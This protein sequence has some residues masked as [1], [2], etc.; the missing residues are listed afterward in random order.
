MDCSTV[1]SVGDL[2]FLLLRADHVDWKELLSRSFGVEQADKEMRDAL[3]D[4]D[5]EFAKEFMVSGAMGL[6]TPATRQAVFCQLSKLISRIRVHS[7]QLLKLLQNN[8]EAITQLK[9]YK[10]FLHWLS[11]L[12]FELISDPDWHKKLMESLAIDENKKIEG[13]NGAEV[14]SKHYLTNGNKDEN[15]EEYEVDDE[16]GI[17]ENDEENSI[18]FATRISALT[19][20]SLIFKPSIDSIG[21]DSFST[22]LDL[23]HW[24]G[25]VEQ[26][27]LLFALDDQ[28]EAC[29]K[30]ALNLLNHFVSI[31]WFQTHSQ[32]SDEEW[33]FLRVR[34]NMPRHQQAIKFRL[35]FHLPRMELKLQLEFIETL[36]KMSEESSNIVTNASEGKEHYFVEAL[37]DSPQLHSL[38]NALH[39]SLPYVNF[40]MLDKGSLF[41]SRILSL[42][43]LVDKI[44]SPV[45]HSLS[46]EG[47]MPSLDDASICVKGLF[48]YNLIEILIIIATDY[49]ICA[50]QLTRTCFRAHK[51]ISGI[52]AH[53]FSQY[54]TSSFSSSLLKNDVNQYL[55]QIASYFWQQLTECRHRGAFEAASN[56]FST[57]VCPRL[58]TICAENCQLNNYKTLFPYSPKQWL[59]QILAAL[60]GKDDSH[61]LCVTRRSAGLPHLIA[62]LLEN[63]P[64]KMLNDEQGLFHQTI[65]Q[66][67]DCSERQNPELEVHCINVLRLLFMHSKFSELVLPHVECAFRVTI[68]GSSSEFWPVRNAHTQ[69]F[70]ALIKRVFGTPAVERRTLH[71][72]SRCKQTANEFFKRYPA[73]FEFFL[74]QI[75]FISNG[76][77]ENSKTSW[78]QFGCKHLFLAFPLLITLTHL[79]PHV[80]CL[81]DLQYSLK[82]FLPNL[83]V[84]LLYVPTHSVRALASAAIL[85]NSTD[86]ELQ[87]ILAWLIL[88]TKIFVNGTSNATQNFVAAIQLLLLH[89]DELKISSC[90]SVSKLSEWI[91]QQKLL[92]N[93]DVT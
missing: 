91:S 22:F 31:G 38:L 47:F 86:S 36:L 25:K 8:A 79:R 23:R 39:V 1:S 19:L 15:I 30:I 59:E 80:L 54:L 13:K 78:H 48:K 17:E 90:E 2:S 34:P 28:F 45:V 32:I 50:Q 4:K 61:K 68:E 81:D 26:Q 11:K 20:I 58:W 29:Q 52:L 84:L 88:Q 57:V 70:A 40:K 87:R 6:K 74:S 14:S 93:Y 62:S 83:L 77:E 73:L 21:S 63:A 53:I 5:F 49:N 9:D 7:R 92:L 66:L 33:L 41:I 46:P 42:C 43:L 16:E 24:I 69:L 56:E 37:L 27:K 75:S 35:Q 71:I 85:S 44:V 82:P 12:A 60:T 67:M 89:M 64:V 76:L 3:M 18:P 65:R 10:E 72:E 51:S 55:S